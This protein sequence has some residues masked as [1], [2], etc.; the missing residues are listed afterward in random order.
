[1]E[2]IVIPSKKIA[3]IGSGLS[4]LSFLQ[5]LSPN[6]NISIKIFEKNSELSNR[7]ITKKNGNYLYD[8]GAN[9][10]ATEDSEIIDLIT[11]K[12]DNTELI[13]IDKWVFPFNKSNDIDLDKEKAKKHNI[14]KK[15]NYKSGLQHL[16]QLLIKNTKFQD[17]QI[18]FNKKIT[19]IHQESEFKYK[20][21]SFEED[22]GE[23][24]YLVF[25]VP[26]PII[27]KIL[28]K[29]KFLFD[30][31]NLFSEGLSENQYKMIFSLA[32]AFSG[33]EDLGYYALINFDREHAISWLSVEN[34]KE[35]HVNEK[36]TL[37]LI[38]QAADWFSQQLYKKE[39]KEIILE[40]KEKLFELLPILKKKMIIFEDLKKWK[41]ALPKVKMN[42]E[43]V[44]FMETKGIFIIGDGL[45]GKGRI[46]GSMKTG[47]EL[48][49]K[50][51]FQKL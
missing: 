30:E 40:I 3:L 19:K 51:E 43:I 25:G 14:L 7:A 12:L 16:S 22:L 17:F 48:G 32:I 44:K 35:G 6:P 11:Q 45:I 37:L 31:K 36:N 49:K 42:E 20:I 21:F 34:E 41:Y 18:I 46:D 29:S 39:E 47:I 26:S 50:L 15:F 38:V 2:K 10:L 28:T 9:Y 5:S 33:F 4:N 23:F 8:I 24:D 27:F 13:E 1:M